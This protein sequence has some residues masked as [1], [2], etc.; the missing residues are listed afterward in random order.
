MFC[1]TELM[2]QVVNKVTGG[3]HRATRR[4]SGGRRV[5]LKALGYQC[6]TIL[7]TFVPSVQ[8]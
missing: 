3:K 5:I 1:F 8:Y 7:Q 6:I 2:F 4:S